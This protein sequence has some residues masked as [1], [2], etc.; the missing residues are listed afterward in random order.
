MP[1]RGMVERYLLPGL[2]RIRLNR[3]TPGQVLELESA[4]LRSGGNRG[5][6]LSARTVE[7]VHR[8][9]HQALQDAVR[10]GLLTQNVAQR[11]EPPRPARYEPRSLTWPQV[12]R[13]LTET[14]E[15]QYRDLFLLAVQTGL[16]CSE[17]VGLQRRDV[18]LSGGFCPYA[19][20]SFPLLARVCGPC[21]R[22]PWRFWRQ[23]WR[24]MTLGMGRSARG[25]MAV[26]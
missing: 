2:G 7:H 1:Y 21:C 16:R 3:L 17:L 20:G 13:L 25:L 14:E 5:A 4:L 24:R 10:S 15:H 8:V 23:G 19:G 26:G 22:S 12:A 18:N 9:L 6:G 11:V